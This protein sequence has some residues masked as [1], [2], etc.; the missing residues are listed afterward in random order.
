MQPRMSNESYLTNN[1]VQKQNKQIICE[2]SR[3]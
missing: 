1:K 3:E 2:T